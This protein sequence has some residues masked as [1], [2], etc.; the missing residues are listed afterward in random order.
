[1]ERPKVWSILSQVEVSS[2]LSE[3]FSN[4]TEV[5]VCVACACGGVRSLLITYGESRATGVFRVVLLLVVDGNI[6]TF[7]SRGLPMMDRLQ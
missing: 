7:P 6:G 4:S 2:K 3:V 5:V 1:M